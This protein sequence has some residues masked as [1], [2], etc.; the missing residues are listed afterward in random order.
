MGWLA[1]ST[2][3]VTCFILTAR[4]PLAAHHAPTWFCKTV[5]KWKSYHAALFS[6]LCYVSK[7]TH[8]CSL[9]HSSPSYDLLLIIACLF[10]TSTTVNEINQTDDPE[11]GPKMFHIRFHCANA[12]LLACWKLTSLLADVHIRVRVR[13]AGQNFGG[14][15]YF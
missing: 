4:F 11:Y 6:P 12:Q 3:A 8:S 1:P 10:V 15:M 9:S 5:H 13:R 2:R 7:Q 14:F